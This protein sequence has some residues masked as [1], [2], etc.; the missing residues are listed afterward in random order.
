MVKCI[1]CGKELKGNQTKYCSSNCAYKAFKGNLTTPY[2][3]QDKKIEDLYRKF[4]EVFWIDKFN[5]I[6]NVTGWKLR[7][8]SYISVKIMGYSVIGTARVTGKHHATIIHHLKGV[9][10]QEIQ[11]AYTYLETKTFNNI[12]NYKL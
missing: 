9:T 4:K 2:I 7:V 5:H 6:T 3:N 10:P 12:F 11:I 1:I 8:F